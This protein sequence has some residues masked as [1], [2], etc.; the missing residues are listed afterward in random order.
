M[1]RGVPS[2]LRPQRS[3]EIAWVTPVARH[4]SISR[5]NPAPIAASSTGTV[6]AVKDRQPL[7]VLV[8]VT[9]IVALE[10]AIPLDQATAG[11][12][13][14]VVSGRRTSPAWRRHFPTVVLA[15]VGLG[16]GLSP[17]F[18]AYYNPSVW[19]SIGIVL[20]VLGAMGTIARP[21][22]VRLP[23][24]LLI[25][26]LSGLGLWALLSMV[27]AQAV[28]QA[29]LGANLWLSYAALALLIDPRA[30]TAR[31]DGPSGVCRS[32]HRARSSDRSV[33]RRTLRTRHGI[34]RTGQAADWQPRSRC[35]RLDRPCAEG[36]RRPKAL[37]RSMRARAGRRSPLPK[38]KKRLGC[39]SVAVTFA[40]DIRL[41][42]G[43]E[44]NLAH[45]RAHSG[46]DPEGGA[47]A[48]PAGGIRN[49]APGR[50]WIPF[51]RQKDRS[52]RSSLNRNRRKAGDPRK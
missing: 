46:C 3:I 34:P 15:L 32:R 6:D 35:R 41:R 51:V 24:A 8:A 7:Y 27:W 52:A 37:P 44:R 30:R 14:R 29:T 20:M 13:V 26:G 40:L 1:L 42:L 47:S 9:A 28:E 17:L 49:P 45:R 4:V 36:Q 50:P 48:V 33:L 21:P 23:T 12:T 38:Q 39:V 5:V 18:S 19:L 10:E 2:K 25:G 43:Y 22:R 16:S 31:C 11:N